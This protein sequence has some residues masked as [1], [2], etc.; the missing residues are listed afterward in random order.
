MQ[1][2]RKSTYS[3]LSELTK[4]SCSETESSS[5][6]SWLNLTSFLKQDPVLWNRRHKYLAYFFSLPYFILWFS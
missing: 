6:P 1:L 4:F 2:T 3:E 5:F